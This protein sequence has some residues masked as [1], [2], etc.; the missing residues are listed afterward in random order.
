MTTK[1]KKIQKARAKKA[2]VDWITWAFVFMA[3]WWIRG[4]CWHHFGTTNVSKI[5]SDSIK[6]AGSLEG[7]LIGL[8]TVVTLALNIKRLFQKRSGE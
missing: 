4:F 3:G 5:V 7:L 2:V 1:D 8:G 6:E